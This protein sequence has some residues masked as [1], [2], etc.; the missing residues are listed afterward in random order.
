MPASYEAVA[1]DLDGTLIRLDV[2]WDAAARDAGA[3][4]EAHGVDA[5]GLSL[6]EI[7]ETATDRGHGPAVSEAIA[8]HERRGARSGE[9]LPLADSLP[10]DLPVG[11]CSLNAESACRVALDRLGVAERVDVVVGRDTT[12]AY[13]P[14]PEPLRY[15][16]ESVGVDPSALLFVGDTDRDRETAEA[17]GVDYEWASDHDPSALRAGAR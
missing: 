8:D 1:Y 3:A 9:R 11:V 10:R 6:W 14:D 16:A 4:L 5:A 12:S 7:L 13:K 17:A 15:L 2:D